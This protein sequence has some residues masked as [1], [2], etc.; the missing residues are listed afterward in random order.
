MG[1]FIVFEGLD[2]AGKSSLIQSVQAELARQQKIIERTREP[3]GTPLAES[4]RNL[5]L[6]TKEE[7]PIDR[8]EL[9]LFA[10]GRAQHVEQKI[11]PALKANKWVLC[12]RF[13]G[14]TVAFQHYGRGLE[15]AAIDWLNTYATAGLKPDQIILLDLT[16]EEASRRAGQRGE[17]DRMESEP[18]DFHQRVRNGYLA[19][20]K[21]ASDVWF[22]L[23][24]AQ[25]TAQLTQ[26]VLGQWKNLG[27][28]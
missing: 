9:L 25:P 17:K 15:R 3:G 6:Q 26:Q 14:S 22:V 21:R 23:D 1:K 4:I 12:D 18:A 10:A 27:W 20:A 16:L 7:S 5:I 2:G 28:L 24:A 13:T 8:T 11:R 19:E